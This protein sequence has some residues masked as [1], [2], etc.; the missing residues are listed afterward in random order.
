MKPSNC[1]PSPG[2]AVFL[3]G[4]MIEFRP[5]SESDVPLI[6]KWINDPRV[7]RTLTVRFPA[8]EGFELEWVRNFNKKSEHDVVLVIMLS[9]KPIGVMGIHEIDWAARIGTIG[10]FIGEPALWG[11]GYGSDA[12]MA[13]VDYAFNALNL[14]KIISKVKAFNKRSLGYNAKCGFVIEGRLKDQHYVDGMYYDEVI[15]SCFRDSEAWARA[16]KVWTTKR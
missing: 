11:K 14:R 10:A 7:R 4:N 5:L 8:T 2:H 16:H 15:L 12:K 13:F 6:T 9:G 3:K 1:P